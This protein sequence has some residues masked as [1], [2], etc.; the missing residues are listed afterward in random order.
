[1]S[2]RFEPEEVPLHCVELGSVRV[3]GTRVSLDTIV[4]AFQCGATAEEIADQYPAVSLPDIYAVIAYYLRHQS[5]VNAYIEE[6]RVEGERL[7]AIWEARY[8]PDG[9]RER[10]LARH[11]HGGV[12]PDAQASSR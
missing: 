10:L 12:V 1:M 6:G 9:R 5:E 7:R 8:P 3:K 11:R 4:E 2:L